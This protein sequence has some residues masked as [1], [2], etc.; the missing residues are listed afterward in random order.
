MRKNAR[1]VTGASRLGLIIKACYATGAT[2]DFRG[3]EW[4]VPQLEVSTKGARTDNLDAD[5][6]NKLAFIDVFQ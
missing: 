5:N 2:I 4:K 3:G 6:D 1:F